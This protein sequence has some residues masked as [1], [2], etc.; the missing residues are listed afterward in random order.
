MSGETKVGLVVAA[1]FLALVGGV[2][3]V[4]HL[5]PTH[6]VETAQAATTAPGSDQVQ[7]SDPVPNAPTQE[8]PQPSTTFTPPASDSS[9]LVPLPAPGSSRSNDPAMLPPPGTTPLPP[10]GGSR[11]TITPPSG[12]TNEGLSP[13]PITTPSPGLSNHKPRKPD[14]PSRPDQDD[15][16]VP[17]PLPPTL[18]TIGHDT[19]ATPPAPAPSEAPS[20]PPPSTSGAPTLPPSGAPTLPPSGAPTLPNPMGSPTP[21]PAIEL[22]GTAPTLPSTTPELP[23]PDANK[24]DLPKPPNPGGSDIPKLPTAGDQ[25]TP[26]N[27]NPMKP[28]DVPGFDPSKPATSNP[29]PANPTP[30]MN[31]MSGGKIDLP[32]PPLSGVKDPKT[33]PPSSPMTGTSK[34]DPIVPLPGIDL[35]KPPVSND[36][37]KTPE[38]TPTLPPDLAGPPPTIPSVK[39]NP[40]DAPPLKNPGIDPPTTTVPPIRPSTPPQTVPPSNTPPRAQDLQEADPSTYDEEWYYCKQGDTLDMICQKY[41]GVTKYATALRQYNLDRNYAATFRSSSPSFNQGQVVKVPPAR[42]LERKYANAVPGMRANPSPNDAT[43]TS[44]PAAGSPTASLGSINHDDTS[45]PTEY[46]VS[47]PNM[48]LRDIARDELHN[49]DEWQR[50]FLLNRSINPSA[51]IPEGTKIYLPRPL[52]RSGQ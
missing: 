17:A 51:P 24:I 3:A 8:N 19:P 18:R 10:I 44:T 12:N 31:P 22:P 21:P 2:F 42:V 47:R 45:T 14:S 20:L 9:A 50:I 52:P 34:P 37:P 36:L 28:L 49:P 40:Q 30:P 11:N 27:P 5:Q 7:K 23:K 32:P 41:Y 1:S 6:Q 26:A 43:M 39:P 29:A 4:K 38:K 15:A 13:P 33:A 16:F 25:P 35:P 46:I 48:T